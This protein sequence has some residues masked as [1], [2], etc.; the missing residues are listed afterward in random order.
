[1][2]SGVTP[3]SSIAL[4]MPMNSQGRPTHSLKPTGLPPER[5]RSRV[6]NA[7]ISRGVEKALCCAGEM[8]SRPRG[9]P[10]VAAISGVTF[11]AGSTPPWPGLAPWLSLI[12]IIFTASR[13][14]CCANRSGS[15]RPASSRQPK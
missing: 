2:K 12:S 7:I 9:T 13:R 8:Q 3:V 15:N 10:R 4:T 1:M 11:A 5:V 14:A 6:M